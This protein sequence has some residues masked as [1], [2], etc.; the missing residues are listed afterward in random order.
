MLISNQANQLYNIIVVAAK[1][2]GWA[3]GRKACQSILDAVVPELEHAKLTTSIEYRYQNLAFVFGEIPNQQWGLLEIWNTANNT[4]LFRL[5]D[6]DRNTIEDITSMPQTLLIRKQK[7]ALVVEQQA[8]HLKTGYG[9]PILDLGQSE[10]TVKQA[11]L[12]LNYYRLSGYHHSFM[13]PQTDKF[14]E[15]ADFRTIVRLHRFDYQLRILLLPLLF[16]VE[17]T[18]RTNIADR[19]S[20]VYGPLG[21]TN[22]WN[23]RSQKYH[24]KFLGETKGIIHRSDELFLKN[25]MKHYGGQVPIWAVVELISFDTLSKLYDNLKTDDQES[26]AKL[27][28]KLSS[29]DISSYL[30]GL[31][32]LR[33]LCSHSIRIY[34]RH[35]NHPIKL[36]EPVVA[37]LARHVPAKYKP[38]PTKLFAYVLAIKQLVDPKMFVEFYTNLLSLTHEYNAEI[39]P[40]RLGLPPE[41][42]S[43][44]KSKKIEHLVVKRFKKY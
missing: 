2:R 28:P 36:S 1:D 22:P 39:E 23:F 3:P 17:L 14:T 8:T 12:N 9:F 33:N 30:K 26:I 43:I 40:K 20:C 41:W 6:T 13:D 35:L 34:N 24:K 37:L 15:E 38:T 4:E 44:L 10:T 7:P 31:S 11:P 21:Y 32:Y 5:H 25:M 19:L 29:A 42:K 27:Y 16:E 18:F